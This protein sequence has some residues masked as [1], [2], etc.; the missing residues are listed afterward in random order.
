MKKIKVNR[1]YIEIG[2]GGKF[3]AKNSKRSHP[4]VPTRK[5]V[6]FRKQ[7]RVTCQAHLRPR[8]TLVDSQVQQ[9]DSWLSN[10]VCWLYHG[11]VVYSRSKWKE[12]SHEGKD[13]IQQIILHL[14][15][16]M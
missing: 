2:D 5:R 7:E 15:E 1:K 10:T 14:V 6:L 4:Y 16:F 11:Q 12:N 13:D 3:W 8:E 9:Y